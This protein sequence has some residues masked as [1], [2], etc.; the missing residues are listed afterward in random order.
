MLDVGAGDKEGEMVGEMLESREE[1]GREWAQAGGRVSPSTAGALD[2][3]NKEPSTNL[4]AP[5]VLTDES[6]GGPG[7]SILPITL[8]WTVP[9]F[10]PSGPSSATACV[11]CGGRAG[12]NKELLLK[13]RTVL[14]PRAFSP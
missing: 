4:Q 2:R 13:S 1:R 7:P 9:T 5:A 10:S 11:Q 3:N 6:L 12:V 14:S 8:G